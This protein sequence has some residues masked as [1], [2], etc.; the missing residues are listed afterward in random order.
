MSPDQMKH[1]ILGFFVYDNTKMAEDDISV[2]VKPHSTA[3]PLWT[4]RGIQVCNERTIQHNATHAQLHQ[5]VRKHQLVELLRDRKPWLQGYQHILTLNS[6][7]ISPLFSSAN[8]PTLWFTIHENTF[9]CI[10]TISLVSRWQS[11]PYTDTHQSVKISVI[12]DKHRHALIIPHKHRHTPFISGQKT[13]QD[14]LSCFI[15]W[16]NK[17]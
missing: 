6:S 15:C 16:K 10:D 1:M 14:L 17:G 8:Q 11:S 9:F 4:C 7:Q 12:S 13:N 5:A 2:S 3:T